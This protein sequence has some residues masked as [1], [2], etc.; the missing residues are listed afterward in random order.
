MILNI[1]K[2]NIR[3]ISMFEYKKTFELI[4]KTYGTN[5]FY[6]LTQ[7]IYDDKNIQLTTKLNRINCMLSLHNKNI[8]NISSNEELSEIKK[9]EI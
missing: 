7:N 9:L 1:T 5:D 2:P 4:K 8:I 6:E 3:S